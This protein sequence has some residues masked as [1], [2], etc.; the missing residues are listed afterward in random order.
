MIRCLLSVNRYQENTYGCYLK[1]I[2]KKIISPN[3]KK[4]AQEDFVMNESEWL[5][6]I[7]CQNK[8]QNDL[9]FLTFPVFKKIRETPS[10]P[11]ILQSTIRKNANIWMQTNVLKWTIS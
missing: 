5:H 2:E 10:L 4:Q 1:E 7:V 6:S 8:T 11:L 9:W 3:N